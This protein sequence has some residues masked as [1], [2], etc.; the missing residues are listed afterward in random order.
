M[1]ANI[2]FTKNYNQTEIAENHDPSRPEKSRHTEEER[3]CNELSAH[4]V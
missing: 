3:Y 2:K 1:R 4:I